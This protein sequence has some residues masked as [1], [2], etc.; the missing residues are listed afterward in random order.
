MTA[1]SQPVMPWRR[2]AMVTVAVAV[3]LVLAGGIAFHHHRNYTRFDWHIAVWIYR[4]VNHRFVR[5]LVH[6]TSPTGVTLLIGAV[7]IAAWM[8]GRKRLAVVTAFG[9]L[10]AIFVTEWVAKPLVARE[11]SVLPTLPPVGSDSYPSGHETGLASLTTVLV[12]V[13][14]AVTASSAWR[15][16]AIA[17]ALVIDLIGS[18]ALVGNFYHYATDTLAAICVSVASIVGLA[19]VLDRFA[20]WRGAVS[21]PDAATL[22]STAHEA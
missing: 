5:D 20:E 12:L 22:A 17:G 13:V 11:L 8:R 19:L 21:S 14:I 9:P 2:T 4:H 10:V 15:L 6:I 16:A 3:A 18:F 7:V 1:P